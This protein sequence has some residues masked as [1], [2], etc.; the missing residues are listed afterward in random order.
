MSAL[1]VDFWSF[2]FQGSAFELKSFR[3][4]RLVGIRPWRLDAVGEFR[5]LGV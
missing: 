4:K 3:V 2:R 1:G 5:G